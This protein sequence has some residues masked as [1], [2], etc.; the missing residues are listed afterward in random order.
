MLNKV[1]ISSNIWSLKIFILTLQIYNSFTGLWC[2]GNTEDFGP[3]VTGS[4]P[5]S[6]T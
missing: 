4:T 3:F 5:V 2:N 6:P 1:N